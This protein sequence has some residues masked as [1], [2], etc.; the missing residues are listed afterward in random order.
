VSS[1]KRSARPACKWPS[2]FMCPSSSCTPMCPRP[3]PT[4]AC[5][6][7]APASTG[8]SWKMLPAPR[9][10][11]RRHLFAEKGWRFNT[12]LHVGAA[13]EQILQ[14]AKA[15]DVGLIVIGTHGRRGLPRALLGSVAEKVVRLSPVPVLTIHKRPLRK[16]GG[17]TQ[18]P[19]LPSHRGCSALAVVG[20][21]LGCPSFTPLALLRQILTTRSLQLS[22]HR[23]TK[24]LTHRRKRL[25]AKPKRRGLATIPF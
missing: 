10:T 24:V 13:S 21:P 1:R 20:L 2:A 23:P 22:S 15:H 3:R 16:D 5:P 14:A 7:C 17:D 8:S 4:R 19:E 6:S 18:V 25:S 12:V 11:K 9:W